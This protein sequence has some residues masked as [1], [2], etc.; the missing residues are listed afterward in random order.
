MNMNFLQQ[1]AEELINAGKDSLLLEDIP[2]TNIKNIT[3][4]IEGTEEFK[5]ANKVKGSII[6]EPIDV[7][8]K[9]VFIIRN[10][11]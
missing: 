8:G 10:T 1:K 11:S 9:K 4:V 6:P 5:A 3:L 2:Y 7:K